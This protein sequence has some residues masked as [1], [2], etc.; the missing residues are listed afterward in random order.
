MDKQEFARSVLDDMV[1]SE[2]D[3]V[4]VVQGFRYLFEGWTASD[5]VFADEVLEQVH[6]NDFSPEEMLEAL[7]ELI[8]ED[9]PDLA[10]D[11]DDPFGLNLTD[12]G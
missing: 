7:I 12:E 4:G 9:F 6:G 10:E 8:K 1:D 3:Y 5:V 11:L 2:H